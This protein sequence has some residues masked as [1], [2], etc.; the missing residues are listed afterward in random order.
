MTQSKE[1]LADVFESVRRRREDRVRRRNVKLAML[2]ATRFTDYEFLN[3]LGTT[4][5]EAQQ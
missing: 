4:I 2:V 1:R 5:F 3:C